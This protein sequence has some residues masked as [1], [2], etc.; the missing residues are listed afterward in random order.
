MGDKG[1]KRGQALAGAHRGLSSVRQPI[2]ALLPQP[3]LPPPSAPAPGPYFYVW[4]WE[5]EGLERQG[6]PPPTWVPLPGGAVGRS[7]L[8]VQR[9]LISSG[10]RP[11]HTAPHCWRPLS[12]EVPLAASG[13]GIRAPPAP[14]SPFFASWR[15]ESLAGLGSCRLDACPPTPPQKSRHHLRVR[16]LHGG[17]SLAGLGFSAGFQKRRP[18]GVKDDLEGVRLEVGRVGGSAGREL[19]ALRDPTGIG[20]GRCH[21]PLL[22]TLLEDCTQPLPMLAPLAERPPWGADIHLK[23]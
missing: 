14:A 2:Q 18:G 19:A 3:K 22:Q 4:S 17:C 13:G 10:D 20:R 15:L 9:P 7:G 6:T 21:V 1:S 12:R 11:H 16:G 5:Q 8:M 23:M